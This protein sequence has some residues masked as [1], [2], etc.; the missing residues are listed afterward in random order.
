M[1]YDD[2]TEAEQDAFWKEATWEKAEM[3]AEDV[4][5]WRREAANKLIEAIEDHF[6]RLGFGG[7][8]N[9]ALAIYAEELARLARLPY[10]EHDCQLSSSP[11]LRSCCRAA[12]RPFPS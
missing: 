2:M 5:R 12:C 1:N 10:P 6:K 9:P 8:G 11:I 3:A 7:V 4:Y